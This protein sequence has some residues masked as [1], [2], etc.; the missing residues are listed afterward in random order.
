M[1]SWSERRGASGCRGRRKSP[2]QIA[3]EAAWRVKLPPEP[4]L[5]VYRPRPLSP[6]E[7]SALREHDFR[8]AEILEQAARQAVSA[9]GFDPD[10]PV[11]WTEIVKGVAQGN[12]EREAAGRVEADQAWDCV[13][14]KMGWPRKPLG[15]SRPRDHAAWV[16]LGARRHFSRLH[17]GRHRR[18]PRAATGRHRR[19][20]GTSASRGDPPEGDEDSDSDGVGPLPPGVGR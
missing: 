16:L 4:D 14:R 2:G 7:A 8:C 18:F 11:V 15:L 13:T 9:A 3:R 5:K 20:T 17:G 10:S 1:F 19:V 12:E 6:S